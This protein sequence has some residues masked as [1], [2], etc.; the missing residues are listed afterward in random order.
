[1]DPTRALKSEKGSGSR[2]LLNAALNKKKSVAIFL[3]ILKVL[4]RGLYPVFG[5]GS[6]K[7]SNPDIKRF[8]L[9]P[10]F[11]SL[12]FRVTFFLINVELFLAR[13]VTIS[14]R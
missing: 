2:L 8:F 13:F 10:V 3:L 4:D 12:F 7:P 14:G 1:M 9:L 6:I 5:S 11:R